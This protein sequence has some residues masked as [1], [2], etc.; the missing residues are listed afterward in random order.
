MCYK[1]RLN[2]NNLCTII[3]RRLLSLLLFLVVADI[4]CADEQLFGYVQDAEVLPRGGRQIYQ[5]V[6]HHQER[7]HGITSAQDYRTGLEYGFTNKL[8]GSLYL[9]AR[10]FQVKDPIFLG[11]ARLDSDQQY[12][13][14]N[15]AARFDGASFALKYN[16]LTPFKPNLFGNIGLTFYV[17]PGY[18][19][20]FYLTGE[21]M[22]SPYLKMRVI[23]QRNF[24][25]DR[26]IATLNIE[27]E[28]VESTI[29]GLVGYHNPGYNWYGGL[30]YLVHSNWYIGFEGTHRA[31]YLQKPVMWVGPN[32]HYAIKHWW[33]TLAWLTRVGR[34]SVNDNYTTEDFYLVDY[35][36][37]EFR[38]KIAFNF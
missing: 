28:L 15:G 36:R 26:L 6:T 4:S 33:F 29:L 19:K 30:S 22:F 20:I 25:E 2:T 8:Q 32:L 17:E 10:S 21:E 24:F 38:L 5:W 23:I 12:S 13:D 14:H 7:I 3:I 37:N 35:K 31:E 27:D 1:W 34:V 9:N 18:S 16:I 11:L